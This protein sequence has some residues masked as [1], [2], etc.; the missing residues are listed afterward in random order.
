MQQL[1]NWK[2]NFHPGTLKHS[3]PHLRCRSVHQS[4]KDSNKLSAGSTS[5]FPK[6]LITLPLFLEQWHTQHFI[7]FYKR[8]NKK[9][10]Q[11]L[12]SQ[13]IRLVLMSI[14]VFHVGRA[15]SV[16]AVLHGQKFGFR[17][18]SPQAAQQQSWV[19]KKASGTSD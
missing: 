19:R 17:A 7:Q 3:T 10:R 6:S 11:A 5:T 15:I 1:V 14:R 9:I 13:W 16:Q 18:G 12:G 2:I 8:K 4:G